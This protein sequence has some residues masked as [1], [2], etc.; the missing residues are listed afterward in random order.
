MPYLTSQALTTSGDGVDFETM[1]S[2]LSSSLREIHT[3][4]ASKLSFE[5]LYRA[6]YKL[7]LKRKGEVL[8]ERVK[9]FEMDWLSTE[10]FGRVK[11]LLSGSLLA[12]ATGG[13]TGTTANEKRIAGERLLKGLKQAWDDHN[14][15][16]SM[17]TDVLMYMDR[18]Y[19]NDKERP[20]IFIASMALFRDHILRSPLFEGENMNV[21][22]ILN[23]VILDQ[24]QM[25]REGDIIDKT[26]IRSC[27]YMLE[28]LYETEDE[29]ED[30]K[31]YLTSFEPEF[32]DAS[33]MF[34][35]HEGE[36]LLR[37]S[38]AGTF[39]RHARMRI[40]EEQ[41]R[42]R[43][44]LSPL[45]APKIKLVLEEQLIKKNIHDVIEMEGSGVKY[46]LDNDRYNE[47][48]LIYDLL[49]RVDEKKDEL[50]RA[51]QKRVV[52]SGTDINS[53]AMTASTAPQPPP[54]SRSETSGDKEERG[55]A[56]S[57]GPPLNQQ[58]VAAL[59]WVDDVLRLK[60]KYETIWRT[61]FDS[62]QGLQTTIT[63]SFTDFINAFPRSAE[64]IS[65][66]LDDN[67]KKGLKGKTEN[68]VDAVLEK[69]ITLIRYIQD[70]DMFERYY[71][72]HLS[73]RLLMGKSLSGDVERQMISRMKME[74]GN[75]FT[76]KLEGMFKD[77][78]VSEDL[79]ANFKTRI[80]QLGDPDPKRIELGIN[81]LTSTMWPLEALAP[82]ANNSS[83][84]ARPNC[85]FPPAIERIKQ[86]FEK[87]YLDKHSGRRLTWQANMGTADLRAIFPKTPSKDASLSK[88]RRHELNVSTYAMVILLQFNE[89]Q[90]GQSYSFE[91]LQ[92]RTNIP[93][94]ELIRNLQSLAVAPKT[95]VLI[96]EPMSKDIKATDRFLFN[97]SF[98]SKFMKIKVGVVTS[99]NKVEGDRERRET[100]KRND[101][102]RG[103]SIEAAVVRIMKYEIPYLLPSFSPSKY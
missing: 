88:E 30:T 73:R 89:L 70:K 29:Q 46:M 43:S 25:E 76:Q 82:S 10:I 44:T 36:S 15:C 78:S 2:I 84:V 61:S 66:F 92:A 39:C 56:E 54:E 34:Y 75:H 47:L 68:E 53:A 21:A 60:V 12:G 26:L 96:K 65:L 49:A 50:R 93:S 97:E 22:M 45:T 6:A 72:K 83:E 102:T 71:K 17:T 77:M 5:E 63:R 57:K 40:N 86:G 33:R 37:G 94:S 41:D 67:L 52:Q 87:F 85:I 16:M 3:K 32:L 62:D 74:V 101:D 81:V 103:G 38:D 28:G 91:E 7:V 23:S 20:S 59:Q 79:T 14:L 90:P 18:V 64:Y 9:T 19:C 11:N 4:N 1:W 13:N 100:E 35:Q 24:I 8:Y 69:A 31:L 58:T 48:E 55:K 42:C 98:H 95:R 99:G 27:A 80:A 51:M